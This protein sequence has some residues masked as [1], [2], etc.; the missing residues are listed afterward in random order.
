MSPGPS[1]SLSAMDK[2]SCSCE[3]HR[4]TGPASARPGPQ[5]PRTDD[6]PGREANRQRFDA[7]SGDGGVDRSQDG[8][9]D[10]AVVPLLALACRHIQRVT[11]SG[12]RDSPLQ[13]PWPWLWPSFC[14]IAH[15]APRPSSAHLP[16]HTV[17]AVITLNEV[18]VSPSPPPMSSSHPVTHSTTHRHHC[19]P[20]I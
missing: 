10:L 9:P 3:Q 12:R 17:H 18:P 1:P 2:H 16:L 15:L 11:R 5:R 13:S 6:V 14:G 19:S 7:D 8:E 4:S 20:P